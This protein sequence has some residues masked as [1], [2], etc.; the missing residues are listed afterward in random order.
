MKFF[1]LIFSTV[2]RSNGTLGFYLTKNI[3]LFSSIRILHL[4]AVLNLELLPY[5]KY[6]TPGRHFKPPNF[7]LTGTAVP[8]DKQM[9]VRTMS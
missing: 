3:N 6:S 2:R 1:G 5:L 8:L 4:L 7:Y 9:H